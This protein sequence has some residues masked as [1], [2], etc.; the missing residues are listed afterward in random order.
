MSADG[1]RLPR[2]WCYD[3]ARVLARVAALRTPACIRFLKGTP[4]PPS[5]I[6]PVRQACFPDAD[7]RR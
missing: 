5:P 1:L 2:L 4:S 6:A 7:L 3:L